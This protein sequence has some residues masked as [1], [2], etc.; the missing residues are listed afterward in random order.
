[1]I[2]PLLYL[3]YIVNIFIGINR[4]K[5]LLDGLSIFFSLKLSKVNQNKLI[6][7][8]KLFDD[9]VYSNKLLKSLP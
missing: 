1:M 9:D 2:F 7:E 3:Q 8:M 6:K 4:N 5:I